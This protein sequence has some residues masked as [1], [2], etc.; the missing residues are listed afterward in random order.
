[1]GIRCYSL[2]MMLMISVQLTA[3]SGNFICSIRL[4]RKTPED[5]FSANVE[6]GCGWYIQF[7]ECVECVVSYYFG[8]GIYGNIPD[9]YL[10]TGDGSRRTCSTCPSGTYITGNCNPPC[11]DTVCSACPPNYYCPG[12][13]N[14]YA[15]RT[16]DNEY[17]PCN[18]SAYSTDQPCIAADYYWDGVAAKLC[19]KCRA[20]TYPFTSCYKSDAVCAECPSSFYCTRQENVT[21]N[22]MAQCPLNSFSK[23]GSK[24]L[25]ECDCKLGMY[26]TS[27][28][29]KSC[30]S[31]FY[32]YNNEK[33]PC[34]TGTTSFP[35]ASSY[36]DCHCKP[37][38]TGTVS[39]AINAT[40]VACPIGQ[41]CPGSPSQPTCNC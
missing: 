22:N 7:G 2:M 39:S 21:Q 37:G 23:P 5:P 27:Q 33:T 4:T 14:K 11:Y 6:K 3:I 13:G 19:T 40:C 15:C 32:C 34:P 20:G 41:F 1:M 36:M 24:S 28:I 31:G 10:C 12:N 29:C 16:C 25:L 35:N 30:E 17:M 38:T 18:A 26:A 8:E 9:G